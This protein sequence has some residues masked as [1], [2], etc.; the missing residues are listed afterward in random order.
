[1]FSGLLDSPISFTLIWVCMIGTRC[2]VW[3]EDIEGLVITARLEDQAR[4]YHLGESE[5]H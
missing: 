5:S 1:M 3:G 2:V 4:D